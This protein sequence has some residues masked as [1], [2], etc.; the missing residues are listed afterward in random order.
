[1]MRGL[2]PEAR[3]GL[4]AALL[5]AV[6]LLFFWPGVAH[7]DSVAQYQQVV[8]GAYN[9]WHPPV[10]A[11]L[12]SLSY[13]LGWAGQGPMF[14]LQTLLWWAGLGLLAA[15]LARSGARIAAL[16]VVA[17]GLWPPLLG[18][19]ALVVKDGQMA[20]ALV[21]ATGIVAW[22]RFAERPVGWVATTAVLL[23]LGYALLVRANAVFA[24]A[25][26]AVG[27]LAP[28]GWQAWR[29]RTV[30]IGAVALAALALSPLINARIFGAEP[31][32]VAATQ[33]L[34]DMAGIA[35]RAG[36]HAV[37]MVPAETWQRLEAERCSSSVLW[38][39]FSIG[40]RCD[41]IQRDL[42]GRPRQE[43]FAAW[44]RAIRAHPDAYLSHRLAHWNAT[45]RWFVPWHFPQAV[46]QAESLPNRLGLA[47]PGRQVIAFDRV[48]GWLANSPLGAPILAFAAALAVLALAKPAQITAHGLAVSLALSAVAM[49]AS[50]L[51]L[52]I[53]SDMRYHLWSMLA[54][55]LSL[56]LLLTQPLPWRRARIALLL[57]ALIA[58][59]SL[60]ARLLLPQIGDDYAAL[61]R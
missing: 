10:M 19:Q 58:L 18:W 16:A 51:F 28:G 39:N 45:M 56:I 20:A 31:S 14:A 44:M 41:Y 57:L 54:A 60:G 5:C 53:A 2:A 13:A 7:Y 17:L 47:T 23:L 12:W 40:K 29:S 24:V 27:L 36:P 55:W 38:D 48:A 4:A 35:H 8:S 30:L 22:K 34:F 11:R 49:E 33:P 43:I 59:T 25:P 52:S 50:F 21:A 61:L 37:P 3:Y 42:T 9:D 15:A 32:G 26:L 1:M 46:P 6:V